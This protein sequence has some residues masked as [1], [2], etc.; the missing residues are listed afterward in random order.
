MAIKEFAMPYINDHQQKFADLKFHIVNQDQLRR[1]ANGGNS[2]LFSYP[3]N[4][5]QQYVEKAKELYPDN[6]EFIDISKLLVQFIDEDGWE[7]FSEY[8]KDFKNTP[9]LIF[10][11]DDPTPDLFDLIIREIE[12]VCRNDK[13]PFLIRTGCLFGT[14]IENV[15]IMEHKAVMNLPHPLVIFYPSKIEDDNIY[16]LNFKLASKYRCTLVK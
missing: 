1:Q 3:P 11:S 13:I 16:F 2:I 14:G 5:E 9:H 8:Y 4:E 6:A 10:R 7:S 15:N 12:S